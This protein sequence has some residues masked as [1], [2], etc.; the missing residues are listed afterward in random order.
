MNILQQFGVASVFGR[1]A[2]I[3]GLTRR[4]LLPPTRCWPAHCGCKCTSFRYLARQ[5][6][7]DNGCTCIGGQI[8]PIAPSWSNGAVVTRNE[9]VLKLSSSLAWLSSIR[10]LP[11]VFPFKCTR[12]GSTCLSVPACQCQVWASRPCSLAIVSNCASVL[13]LFSF[14][15]VRHWPPCPLTM[16]FSR[17]AKSAA[18][19]AE[20]AAES[21]SAPVQGSLLRLAWCWVFDARL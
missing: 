2:V 7:S 21:H 1:R 17:T 13:Q 20:R 4:N 15:Q 5:S 9:W 16:R 8:T 10:C 6:N 3:L 18:V 14:R 12:P 19:R 11:G